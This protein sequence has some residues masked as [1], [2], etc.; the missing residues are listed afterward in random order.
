MATPSEKLAESL[1]VLKELQDR[2]V[3]A[4]KS[5]ALSRTHRERLQ[6]NHF[7][8]EVHRGW[9]LAVPPTA[10]KGDSTPWY[11]NYWEFCA[12]YL[13]DRFGK[14]WCIAPEQSLLLHAGNYS[15][16][17]QLIVRSPKANHQTVPLLHNTSLFLL[18]ADLPTKNERTNEGGLHLYSL[19]A[20]LVRSAPNIF[21]QNS[22][23]VR[24]ALSMTRDASDILA[25]LLEGGHSLIA[26]RLAGA[27]RN[28]G[29][30]RIADTIISTM[31]KTGYDVRE[32]DPFNTKLDL[33]LSDRVHSPYGN[34]IRLMWKEMRA[35]VLPNFPTPPGLPASTDSYLKEVEAIYVT[36]AYHSLS[37]EK[38]KV[39]PDLIERVR[40]GSWDAKGNQE[41]RQQR[42]TMAARGYFDAFKAVE[43]SIHRILKGENP[44]QVAD[45]DHSIWYRELLG[46][47]V[48]AG[49][50]KAAD[51]AGYR[52]HQVYIGGS[53]HTPLNREAVRDAMPVLFE[54][55]SEEKEASVRA[56]LGHFIFVFIHPYMGGNGRMG[57][58]LMNAMLAS[59][60]YPW[61]VIPVEQRDQ[62]MKAL[63]SAS[64]KSNIEPFA[65]FLGYL[66]G[67]AM[68][69]TSVAKI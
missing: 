57:R 23:D 8:E 50:L 1:S 3:V 34:R 33:P 55:L 25:L 21:T 9:Y 54:L 46:P 41:D 16:P 14:A 35:K 60:G 32:A 42:D 51:L 11:S 18:R 36:D 27:F 48:T 38:Y 37:I 28:I 47:S 4:I 15:V 59:G 22:I 19:A 10:A 66:V 13:E 6:D 39:T 58:F 52:N 43:T 5:D 56:V 7:L 2:G 69:G 65:Q 30:G 31:E 45:E 26:G 17:A 44:G 29:Q 12:Q 61:T 20:A 49:I 40:T 64:V 62:Y 63:E 68:K 53:M 67:E 24:T